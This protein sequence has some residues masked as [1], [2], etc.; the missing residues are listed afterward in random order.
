MKK[1]IITSILVLA[2]GSLQAQSTNQIPKLVVTLTID[3]LRTDYLETFSSLYGENGFK[4]LMREGKVYTNAQFTFDGA[5]RA[6]S[7]ATIYSGTTPSLNGIVSENWLDTKT[8]RPI[9]CV[10]DPEFMGNYTAESSSPGKL[11]TSTLSDE[12]RIATGNKGLVYAIAPFRDAAIL[13]AGHNANSALWINELTGKWCSTTY[14][15]E[16]PWWVSQYNERWSPDFRIKDIE[17]SP[18]YPAERYTFLPNWRDNSFKHRFESERI[19]KFR[20]LITSPLVNDEINLLTEE[21]L[22]KSTIAND[23]TP[24]LLALTYYAGNYN[25][26]PTQECA[27]ELQDAYVRLDNSISRL[28]DILDRKVGMENVL[29]CITSTGY[30]EPD[31]PDVGLYRTPG[32]EFH[33]TRCATLLNMYLMATYGQGQF[34]E[35]YY[36]KQIYLNHKLIE[37][38]QLDLT[39]ILEKSEAF[40]M[41]FSGV[42]EVYSKHRLLLGNWSPR[43]ERIRNAYNRLRS[44]DLVIDVLPGWTIIDEKSNNNRVVR[45]T[46]IP[47][48][49]IFIG[50][51]IKAE[52][53][54]TPVNLEQVAPTLANR[55]RIRAPNATKAATLF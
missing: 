3:Q 16:F 18:I 27:M 43:L 2:F 47:A 48:P 53:I 24:D 15:G 23:Q 28:L 52:K 39:E 31:S 22:S 10:D 37:D 6:S 46:I 9:N 13:S 7:I 11:L 34:V 30:T 50:N 17:W 29:L 1:S 54:A 42:N 35:A 41:Q 33:L 51:D 55:L 32:G 14:Y 36:D 49:I 4:R 21:L 26:L 38:K 8:L 45:S 5:D 20:R 40:L 25:H 44:G 19:N 12:I